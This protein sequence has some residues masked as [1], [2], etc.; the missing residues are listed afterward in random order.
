MQY[1]GTLKLKKPDGTDIVNIQDLNDNT[2]ILEIEVTK[3]A[4]TTADGRMSKED[5]VKLDGIRIATQAEAEAG[6][7]DTKHMTPLKTKQAV[8]KQTESIVTQLNQIATQTVY[9]AQEY[10]TKTFANQIF[11]KVL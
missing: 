4:S 2:D 3:K 5:K 7:S 10:P 6:V 9:I 8:T 1:T 11:Y